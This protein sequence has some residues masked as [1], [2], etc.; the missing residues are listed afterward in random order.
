MNSMA[1]TMTELAPLNRLEL[2]GITSLH[3]GHDLANQITIL[4]ALTDNLRN[5]ARETWIGTVCRE[6]ES[7]ARTLT[8]LV[9]RLDAARSLIPQTPAQ[10]SIRSAVALLMEAASL[11]GWESHASQFP[12]GHLR[13]DA[14][15]LARCVRT[16]AEAAQAP[17]KFHVSWKQRGS[18]ELATAGIQIRFQTPDAPSLRRMQPPCEILTPYL[19]HIACPLTIHP[20]DTC[21]IFIP[22][23]TE[24][25]SQA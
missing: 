12:Q 10:T 15:L 2:L 19:K 7:T 21:Q 18:D 22:A 9:D 24:Q 16:L 8:A 11:A 14:T 6:L 4:S 23:Y 17:G 25:E 3:I 20:P 13:Y 5:R 1:A